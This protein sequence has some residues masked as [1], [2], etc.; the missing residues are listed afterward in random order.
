MLLGNLHARVAVAA[1]ALGWRRLASRLLFLLLLLRFRP[2]D[3]GAV[4]I[5]V[6]NSCVRGPV[7]FVC[8]GVAPALGE[9]A[10]KL[11]GAVDRVGAQRL[12][13]RWQQ[14]PDGRKRS[15]ITGRERPFFSKHF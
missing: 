8:C 13:E 15:L 3:I 11:V 10:E 9:A 14:W 12:V 1:R 7:P 2:D 6:A 4:R 5:R